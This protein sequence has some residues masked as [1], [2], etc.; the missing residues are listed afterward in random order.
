MRRLLD[1]IGLDRPRDPR[2]GDVRLGELR[3]PVHHHHGGVPRLLRLGR[4]RR[5]ARRRRPPRASPRRPRSRWRSSRS[6]RRS[7]APTPTSPA[8]RSA[9][10]RCSWPSAS[11][12]RRRC[13]SSTRATGASRSALFVVA[14][15]GISGSFVFYDS[16]LPH[17]ASDAEMDRVS[18][19][20]YALGYLGG[21]LL[22][23]L[24]LL[25]IMKP[26]LVRPARRGHGLA[27]VV[28][29]RRGLVGRVLDPAV[30]ARERA[31]GDAR[32]R[33]ARRRQHRCA[34]RSC[35]S[36]TRCASSAVPA[37]RADAARVSHLQRRHRHDHPDG[38]PLRRPR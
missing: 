33:G 2:V 23:V 19:A 37:G 27:P 6:P 7:S 5:P 31:A 22:L 9:C 4:R 38:G 34:R 18:S 32:R 26:A 12:P 14:N 1:R 17:I 8:P 24:N 16:L 35:S 13:S 11:P 29:E 28:P 25:W 36:P 10:W 30:P 3:V 21:G 15:I 20:G